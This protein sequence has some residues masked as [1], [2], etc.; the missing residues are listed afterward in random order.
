MIRRSLHK[1]FT[2][3]VATGG[4][5]GVMMASNV[6]Q[7]RYNATPDKEEV[8]SRLIEKMSVTAGRDS[9]A[10]IVEKLSS[11]ERVQLLLSMEEAASHPPPHADP[12]S[13][14][15][16]GAPPPNPKEGMAAIPYKPL[17]LPQL[18]RLAIRCAVP[19]FGFGVCDNLIMICVGDAIDSAF[20][21]TLGFSTMVAAGLGQ[22][23][24][25]G[26]GITIQ[27]FIENW[28]DR[29]G[30]P[31]PNLSPAQES[32]WKTQ[33]YLQFFRTF[34]IVLG[35]LVGLIPVI[36]FD[37]GNRPRLTDEILTTLP[38]SQ[39]AG[40]RAKQTHCTFREGDYLM[41]FGEEA[42]ALFTVLSGEL[43]V[44]GRN[45]FGEPTDI[46]SHIPGDSTGVVEIVFGHKC[47]ADV[48]VVTPTARCM[49]LRREDIEAVEGGMSSMRKTVQDYI[50]RDDD[51][52]PYRMR[53]MHSAP[54][55]EDDD[56]DDE[57]PAGVTSTVEAVEDCRNRI[58]TDGVDEGAQATTSI[59]PPKPPVAPEESAAARAQRKKDKRAAR[60]NELSDGCIDVYY[61][62]QALEINKWVM[63]KSGR[64]D[65]DAEEQD[66][67]STPS[68]QG[69]APTA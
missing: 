24:S 31:K 17:E 63:A 29:L 42:P 14:S 30:L 66:A 4:G 12:P 9:A 36:M 26:S 68:S 45:D 23:V 11:A 25:D 49:M 65:E 60:L 57:I 48:I 1:A 3:T 6:Y 39:R 69:E 67:A 52:L 58:A 22:A 34:G 35:C 28:A 44:V 54:G 2:N 56:D 50:T 8:T 7:R 16:D 15:L 53:F 61:N 37:T 41:Q 27:G 13:P 62:N 64:H 33:W 21:V 38:E 18:W 55:D 47:V 40:L 10:S 46:A 19:F 32:H 43:K 5:F 59:P 51:F 20:G